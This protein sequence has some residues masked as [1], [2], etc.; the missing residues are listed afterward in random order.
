MSNAGVLATPAI[1]QIIHRGMPAMTPRTK[2][3]YAA[4]E[5][6]YNTEGGQS[7][8]NPTSMAQSYS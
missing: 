4:D 6:Q 1:G 3:L 5:R 2:T 8:E 7:E